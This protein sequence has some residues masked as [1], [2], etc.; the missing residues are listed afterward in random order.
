MHR[1]VWRWL[2]LADHH[3]LATAGR[4][5]RLGHLGRIRSA[6]AAHLR[7]LVVRLPL[8][9]SRRVAL[10]PER[11]LPRP[12]GAARGAELGDG[13]LMQADAISVVL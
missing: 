2:R 1:S 8:P 6:R 10:A 9:L 5:I 12:G 11:R 4:R 3:L 7:L 13:A